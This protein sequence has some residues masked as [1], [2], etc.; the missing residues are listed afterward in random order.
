MNQSIT[1]YGVDVAITRTDDLDKVM[2]SEIEHWLA[3]KILDIGSGAGGQAIRLAKK[4]AIVTAVD[5]CDF[6]NE[7]SSLMINNSLASESITFIQANI[8]DIISGFETNSF[9][10]AYLQ[11]ML[12]YLPYQEAKTVLTELRRIVNG[13]LYLSI[14]GLHSDIGRDYDDKNKSITERFCYLSELDSKTFSINQPLCLY[15]EPEAKEL[16]IASGWQIEKVW[17]SAF[18][19]IKVICS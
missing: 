17:V 11:R 6:N 10:A 1:N 14:T 8:I 16:L 2:L 15:T 5:I 4:G 18:G 3:P 7:I 19:N 12:H 9:N 13:K